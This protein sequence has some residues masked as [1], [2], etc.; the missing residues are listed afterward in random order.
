MMT[1]DL[2]CND[3]EYSTDNYDV[4]Y[5]LFS[6]E[7]IVVSNQSDIHNSTQQLITCS[8]SAK[9]TLEKGVKYSKLTIRTPE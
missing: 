3:F 6:F 7:W 2:T 9:G 5:N 8:K 1:S 4:K